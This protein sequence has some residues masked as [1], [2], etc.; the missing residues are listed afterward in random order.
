MKIIRTITGLTMITLSSL[1][2]AADSE[3]AAILKCKAMQGDAA[4]LACYDAL[5]S[6]ASAKPPAPPS[7][8]PTPTKSS[9]DALPV[10]ETAT[11]AKESAPVLDDDI[12]R[13]NMAPAGGEQLTVRGDV[14]SCRENL[15][16]KLVFT[17][18]SGQVWQQ[19]DNKNPR[20][21]DCEFSVTIRKDYFGYIMKP[22][23]NDKEIR[24]ARVK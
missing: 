22:D 4:R 18:A 5:D 15:T 21:R 9:A 13:E 14:V 6:E 10:V 16:G 19:K 7:A 17:F 12:G 23:N 1:S 20:W 2:L 24:I 3:V 8:P 11:V